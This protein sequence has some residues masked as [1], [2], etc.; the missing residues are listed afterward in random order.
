MCFINSW[1]SSYDY[2]VSMRLEAPKDDVKPWHGL[3]KT[4]KN[5]EV[6]FPFG[7]MYSS[8]YVP[9]NCWEDDNGEFYLSATTVAYLDLIKAYNWHEN[10]PPI[11]EEDVFEGLKRLY[12]VLNENN[13]G[14]LV[15]KN[16]GFLLF[17]SSLDEMENMSRICK[18]F[19]R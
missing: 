9:V 12:N 11:S 2:G 5:V 10:N 15:L 8:L 13:D 1:T 14:A 4:V 19:M 3:S 6:I 7:K 18:F 17:S 16:H